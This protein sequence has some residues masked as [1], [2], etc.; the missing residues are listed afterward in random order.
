ME[1][2]PVAAIV[3]PTAS[4]KSTLGIELCSV[5][6]GEVVSADSMQIYKKMDISTAKPSKE[7]MK[8]ITHHLIDLLEPTENF[9]VVK[10]CEMARTCISDINNRGKLPVVVGGTGLYMDSLLNNID[11]SKESSNLS[12]RKSLKEKA[13]VDG[14]E[15]L[16]HELEKVDPLSALKIHPNDTGRIIRALELYH[17][18]GITAFE[19]NR[20]SKLQ[21]SPYRS[22]I[23]GLN[24]R[25]RQILYDR[26]NTRID[27]MVEA[28]LFEEAKN[29]FAMSR[30]STAQQAIGIKEL[31]PF[32]EGNINIDEA[33]QNL[34]RETRRY[35]KRQLTW[36][37]KNESVKW[38][39]VDD[40]T[41]NSEITAQALCLIEQDGF[42][43]RG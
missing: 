11:F 41:D 30:T 40:Y 17:T 7:E 34:K 42:I 28:G 3:G 24:F 8:G 12:L 14:S 36:F 38:I 29:L 35:A 22:I 27:V 15:Y 4:G 6:S 31:Y 21:S 5:F 16:Y 32:F 13:L 33:L 25:N 20:L 1:K 19:Q 10:Y 43:K 37:R 39:Y 26:I 9:N 23:I 2:I 18:T